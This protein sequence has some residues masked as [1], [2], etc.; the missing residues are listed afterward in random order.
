MRY[1]LALHLPESARCVNHFNL[2]ENPQT[3]ETDAT[4]SFFLFAETLAIIERMNEEIIQKVSSFRSLL[5][6][7]ATGKRWTETGVA[8]AYKQRREALLAEPEIADCIPFFVINHE[9]PQEFWRF[10][11]PKF[12]TYAERRMFLD[13]AFE[14]LIAKLSSPNIQQQQEPVALPCSETAYPSPG[15]TV[16]VQCSKKLVILVHGIRTRAEWQ[17]R[18]RHMFEQAGDVCVESIGYGY[19]DVFRFLIPFWTR[20]KPIQTVCK[21]IREALVLHKNT[22]SELIII[23]HS[24]G[25]YIVGKILEEQHDIKPDRVLLCGSVLPTEFPWNRMV[26]RPSVILN[27][28]GSRDIW[29]ILA[30]SLTWGFGAS[31]TFGFQ[32]PG[33]RDRFHNLAHS[34][35]FVGDFAEHYWVPWVQKG[36]ILPTDFEKNHRPPTPYWRNLLAVIP[37]RWILLILF[38]ALPISIFWK[39]TGNVAKEK[40]SSGPFSKLTPSSTTTNP[41]GHSV[42]ALAALQ[43][44]TNTFIKEHTNGGTFHLGAT[45]ASLQSTNSDFADEEAESFLKNPAR[46]EKQRVT[47]ILRAYC[48]QIIVAANL[49]P[50]KEG[51]VITSNLASHYPDLEPYAFW[52]NKYPNHIF[53]ALSITTEFEADHE[54]HSWYRSYIV[55]GQNAGGSRVFWSSNKSGMEQLNP[56]EGN[57]K[58]IQ[59]L[60][61]F[62]SAEIQRQRALIA[63]DVRKMKR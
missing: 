21:K 39:S 9:T 52:V 15:T 1:S 12:A 24:F 14:P 13:D 31:G 49:P 32:S 5:I 35:Y 22:H 26:N 29:P 20:E 43:A 59:Y 38:L 6:S 28:A 48:D 8:E 37:A 30:Q 58:R 45:D 4:P 46:L 56:P 40:D 7:L 11:K 2:Y 54:N 10:I 55:I 33:V 60:S 50:A 3:T 63:E 19:F 34:D 16:P 61:D 23:S 42:R 62:V 36:E 18:L 53:S 17:G 57:E 27:E 41:P 51:A 44:S 25:T 47:A